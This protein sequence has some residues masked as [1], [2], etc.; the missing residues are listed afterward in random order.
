MASPVPST[1]RL[2]L[3]VT[4][5]SASVIVPAVIIRVPPLTVK[6][7]PVNPAA[8]LIV[9]PSSAATSIALFPAGTST[10]AAT[11]ISPLI[12]I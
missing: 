3:P 1:F 10:E 8:R 2:P 7:L 4:F 12:F 11:S 6:I 9:V 5:P